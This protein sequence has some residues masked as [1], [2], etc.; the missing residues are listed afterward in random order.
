V[1]SFSCRGTAKKESEIVEILEAFDLTRC[2]WS[3]AQLAG[4]DPKTVQ[5]YVDRR[6]AGRDPFQRSHRTRLVDP[7]LEKMEELVER[8]RGKI[9]ADV[10]HRRLVAMG[11]SGDERTTRRAVAQAKATYEVGRRRVYRPWIPEP[12]MWLQYDWS[13]GPEV[14][15]RPT[16]LF[17][18]WL[19][20]SRYRVVLPTWDRVL[21]TVLVS[22][23]TTLRQLGGAPTY[24]LTDNERTVTIDRVA[25]VPVRHTEMVAAARHYGVQLLTCVPADPQT[26]GGSEATVRISQADLVP[27]QANLLEDYGSF[28]ALVQA[29]ERFV[30]EVNARPHRETRRSPLE[31]LSQERAHLHGLPNEPYTAALGETRTVN[32]DR[33]IRFGSVRYSVPPGHEGQEVWCRVAGE[34]LVITGRGEQGL[35]EVTRHRLS[36]PGRPQ[37]LAEHYP[38]HPNG[39]GIKQPRLRPQR[40]EEEAFLAIGEGA[41]LWLREAAAAGVPR[42]RSKMAEACQLACLFSRGKV[43][44]ALA[45]AALAGRFGE[46]D[47]A[48]IL[49]HLQQNSANERQTRADERFS[50]QSGTSAWDGFGR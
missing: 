18:A 28:G 50:T 40:P 46:G 17:C 29:R 6:D 22:L 24:I 12:G 11:F 36:V 5:R 26:K 39:Q 19:A 25:G 20:W 15:G 4:C 14:R 27:T 33:T 45:R 48:S 41:E 42:I 31:A 30:S 9:R 7:F 2:V 35:A 3:A 44:F 1:G 37:I 34:E 16:S 10:V 23:D 21:G 43:S 47:L 13:D 38:D 32:P 49:G 8:S